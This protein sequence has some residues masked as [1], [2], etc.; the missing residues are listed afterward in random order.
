MKAEPK[1]VK[2]STDESLQN[3]ITQ[4]QNSSQ[5]AAAFEFETDELWNKFAIAINLDLEIFERCGYLF[6]KKSNV[7]ISKSKDGYIWIST[8]GLVAKSRITNNRFLNACCWQKII[9][10]HLIDEAIPLANDESTYD[11]DSLN[12]SVIESLTPAIFHNLLFYFEIFAKAYLEICGKK[13]PHTHSLKKLLKLAKET[14]FE[15][16]QNNTLF[17]AYAISA[18]ESVTNYVESIPEPFKEEYV[19]YDDNPDDVTFVVFDAEYLKEMRESIKIIYE[20]VSDM[21]YNLDN[22][23]CCKNNLYQKLLDDAKT[24]EKKKRIVEKYGYLLDG[25]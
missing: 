22:C 10:L 9:L 8:V 14:M 18:L 6:D 7:H 16:Q 17:H 5:F 24:K 11:I 15:K 1:K 4:Y 2:I 19:K 25:E 12:Y 13:V 3:L 23:Y 21:Y 20:M